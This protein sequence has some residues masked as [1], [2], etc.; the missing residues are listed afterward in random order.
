MSRVGKRAF[1]KT[2]KTPVNKQPHP[3]EPRVAQRLEGWATTTVYPTLRDGPA[4]LLRVRL[5]YQRFVHCSQNGL[6][7]ANIGRGERCASRI[8][9]KQA[10]CWRYN[11]STFRLGTS[12]Q[13]IGRRTRPTK[14]R[15]RHDHKHVARRPTPAASPRGS[16]SPGS[17]SSWRPWSLPW[18]LRRAPRPGRRGDKADRA[19]RPGG[20]TD[21]VARL[22]AQPLGEAL[23]NRSSSRTKPGASGLVGRRA[24]QRRRPTATPSSCFVDANT[25]LPSTVK[26]L[27][28]DPLKSFAPITVLGRG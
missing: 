10:K 19:A 2:S 6:S 5:A 3:E 28:H 15:L 7:L 4:G 26:Q 17:W 25:I 16:C 20:V 27:N 9:W 1:S 21:V 23:G 24:R 18:P 13:W 12:V 14:G 8:H 11:R 22:V